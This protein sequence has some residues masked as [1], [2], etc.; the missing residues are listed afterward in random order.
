MKYPLTALLWGVA[1]TLSS[2]VIDNSSG[3]ELLGPP[4]FNPGFIRANKIAALEG[5]KSLKRESDIIRPERETI[6][7]QFDR[8]GRLVK[9]DKRKG[10]VGSGSEITSTVYRYDRNGRL[11]DRIEADVS[12]ATSFS[13]AYDDA[14]RVVRET[15][16]RM[17]SPK[18][19]LLPAGPKRTEIYAESFT[20]TDLDNGYK[21]TTLNSYG[22]PYREAFYY[23]DDNG[24]LVETSSRYLVNNRMSRQTFEY[25][26]RGLLAEK[27]MIKDLAVQD[28]V[29]FSYNYD[30]AGNLEQVLEYFNGELLRRGE[31]LYDPKTWMLDARLV[32]VEETESIRI[33]QYETRYFKP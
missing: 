32:K 11:I 15:C 31:F 33:V 4:A 28:T 5:E 24:Y 16:S 29:R 30:D 3:V 20:Y 6:A 14:D 9:V 1:L 8:T 17:E 13:Y 23:F 21:K 10:P 18:D 7:Y 19:T 27:V 2:Q 25:N 12:G 22:R 26:E